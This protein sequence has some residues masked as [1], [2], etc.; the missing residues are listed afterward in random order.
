MAIT[1]SIAN[2]AKVEFLLGAHQLGGNVTPTG[3]ASANST[4]LT[5]SST[6]GVAAGMNANGVNI[7]NGSVIS[8]VT[9]A[10]TVTLSLATT[11]S[12]TGNTVTI[13]GDTFACALIKANAVGTYGSGTTNYSNVVSNGDEV[14][15]TG[16][17]AGGVALTS[18]GPVLS[19]S[20]ACI[21]F[22]TN[23]TWANA[24]FS[25][26]GCIVYN[27]AWFNGSNGAALAVYDFGGAQTVSGGAFTVILPTDAAGTAMIQI[28]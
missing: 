19:G 8:S 14:T 16:Y 25:A 17:T 3:T 6:T 27:T 18:I 12:L 4:T 10:T 22:T 26:V 23:P 11:G 2:S 1:T 9:N 5:L 28:A 24:T 13:S 15:G 7:A 20:T 21:S